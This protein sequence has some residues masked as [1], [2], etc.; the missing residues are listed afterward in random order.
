MCLF[1]SGVSS[2]DLHFFAAFAVQFAPQCRSIRLPNMD[3][4][5]CPGATVIDLHVVER[6]GTAAVS[7]TLRADPLE[8]AVELRLVNFE[9]AV[10]SRSLYL[11]PQGFFN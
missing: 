6:R 5:P 10:S 2:L 1:I 4:P 3:H 7:N 11:A 8:D 9:G